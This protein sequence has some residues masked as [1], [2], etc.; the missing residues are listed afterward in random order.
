[1]AADEHRGLSEHQTR[2]DAT[3]RS[4]CSGGEALREDKVVGVVRPAGGCGEEVAV[5]GLSGVQPPRRYADEI[6]RPW[7]TRSRHG[8]G[9][10]PADAPPAQGGHGS[11][12][13]LAVERM[14]EHHRRSVTIVDDVDQAGLLK[15]LQR[16]WGDE[17][18]QLLQRHPVG[19]GN[20]I[21]RRPG[22]F[23]EGDETSAD[24]FDETPRRAR[25]AAQTPDPA[26]VLE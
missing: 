22:R 16:T 8:V 13:C 21:E 6:S 1:M 15:S 24:Q 4:S 19:H 23:V 7:H 18:G 2:L 20:D 11:Q 25:R 3:T 12:H 9:D 14:S 26:F 17:V 5:D 10:Q